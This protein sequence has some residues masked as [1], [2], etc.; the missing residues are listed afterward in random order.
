MRRK[1]MI[2]ITILFEDKEI[3]IK[4]KNYYGM[5]YTF[6]NVGFYHTCPGAYAIS[7]TN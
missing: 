6:N 2:K 3:N 5:T 7:P 4:E 1:K